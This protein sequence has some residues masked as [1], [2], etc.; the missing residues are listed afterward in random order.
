MVKTRRKSI[1]RRGQNKVEVYTEWWSNKEEVNTERWPKQ[2]GSQY[3]EVV[4]TRWKS[5]QRGDQ[6]KE[7]VHTERWSKQGGSPY[8]EVV[9]T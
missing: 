3:R 2:G 7:V 6:N 4:K 8:R 1:Q 5:I 9:K